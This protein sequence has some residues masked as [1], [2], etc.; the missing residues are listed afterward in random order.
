MALIREYLSLAIDF[1]ASWIQAA[2]FPRGGSSRTPH[3]KMASGF[4]R[5]IAAC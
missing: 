5:E 1:N 4:L 3:P 2:L